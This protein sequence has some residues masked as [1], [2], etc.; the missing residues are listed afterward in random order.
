MFFKIVVLKNFAIFTGKTPVLESLFNKIAGLKACNFT[1][2]SLQHRICVG[3]T[4]EYC[5]SC[6]Y[7]GKFKEQLSY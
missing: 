2:N 3:V 4:C 6:E 5:V 1:E 7:C